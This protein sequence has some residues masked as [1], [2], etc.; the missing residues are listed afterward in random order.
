MRAGR[1]VLSNRPRPPPSACK[2]R[3]VEESTEILWAPTPE[4][5]ERSQLTRYMRWLAENRDL[6]FADYHALWRW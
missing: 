2:D 4:T 6:H 3:A 5:V 1:P